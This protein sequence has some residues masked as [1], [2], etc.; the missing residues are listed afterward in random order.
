[1]PEPVTYRGMTLLVPDNDSEWKEFY[2]HAR[3]HRLGV[4]PCAACGLL[5]YPP[6]HACPWCMDL[7][8]AW[9][10]VGGRGT[11]YSYEIVHHAIQPGV[12][13]LTAYPVVAPGADRRPR[14]PAPR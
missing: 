12:K 2:A 3:A 6:S 14:G 5:R 9:Q 10:E 8:W 7:G 4:R 11:I 13:A 1:M